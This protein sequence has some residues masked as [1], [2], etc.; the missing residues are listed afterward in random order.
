MSARWT[1]LM[2]APWLA[3]SLLSSPSNALDNKKKTGRD[4]EYLDNGVVR[5]GIDKSRGACIGYLAE[6]KTKRNLLNNH[7][8]GRFIQQ[9]YYGR[10]DGSKWN[11]KPWVYNPVQGG[12]AKG[13]SS[14]LLKFSRD[15]KKKTISARVEPLS[16]ASGIAC[17]EAL[18]GVTISLE[19]PL[20][21]VRFR[22][23]Y[24]GKD[25][26]VVR[27]Q[28]M[29]AVF[30]D[31]ELP[32]L[33][34]SESGKL[35]RRVPGWPNE[36]GKASENWV[37]Y[38]DDKDWGIGIYT[39]G[40]ETFTC[41]RFKGDGKTGPTGSAC[42]YVAPLRRFSLQKGLAVDYEVFLTIGSLA[43]I[44]KRFASLRRK[45]APGPE[46]GNKRK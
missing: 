24:T 3:L 35:K 18:M 11:G 27:D 41:Y 12:Y 45:A 44:R 14:R 43:E 21:R 1:F 29:P 4:W 16:W 37:A 8:E 33:V 39:P 36:R 23:D 38:L 34:Y 46:A 25:Q 13:K 2:L 42:S 9:S 22:M 30:V 26:S 40:T 31:A 5:I 19:G 15:K 17:P 7:D 20:A 6:S 28:E 32:N 10:P